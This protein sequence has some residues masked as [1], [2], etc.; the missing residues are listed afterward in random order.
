[1]QFNKSVIDY[2]KNL[3]DNYFV[4]NYSLL[5][6]GNSLVTIMLMCIELFFYIKRDFCILEY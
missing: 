2:N 1:M 6:L 3:L 4:E 5:F